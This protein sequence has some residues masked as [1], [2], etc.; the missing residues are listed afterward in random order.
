MAQVT[1]EQQR[2]TA[3]DGDGRPHHDA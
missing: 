2:E 3:Q 1:A